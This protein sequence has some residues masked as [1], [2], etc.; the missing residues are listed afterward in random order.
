M[1]QKGPRPIIL[2]G[3]SGS[4]KSTLIKLLFNEYPDKFGFSVSH[5][6]RQP[7]PGE[8]HGK[9]YYFTTKE[10]M[11]EQ[12]DRG[13]FLETAVFSNNM[14]GTSK[15]AVEDVQKSGKICILDIETEGVKQIKKSS[16]NP[17]FIFIKPPSIQELEKRLVGRKTETN[18]SMQRRLSSAKAEIEFGETPGNFDLV[19]INDN[20]DKAYEKLRDF[21]MKESSQQIQ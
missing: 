16:L 2:C 9:H 6:T 11:Q 19:V 1:L 4:G 3:P 7:R 14:Y 18:D 21:I 15:K 20:I 17:L 5:T 13:E 12:I 8:E 10:V